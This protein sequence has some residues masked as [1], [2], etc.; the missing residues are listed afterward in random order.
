MPQHSTRPGLPPALAS[1]LLLIHV[2][3]AGDSA[4]PPDL[5]QSLP[6]ELRLEAALEPIRAASGVPGLAAAVVDR[7]GVVAVGAVGRRRIDEETALTVAD[8][9][10]LGSDTK[11]MTAFL[12]ARLVERGRIRWDLT[13]EQAP[14]H[15]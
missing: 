15:R 14:S 11:A 12:A 3:C 4:R 13:L 9:F 6:R 7:G 2:A 1:L 5:G 10:H 8:N